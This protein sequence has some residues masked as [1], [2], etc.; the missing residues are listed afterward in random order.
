M[1]ISAKDVM[2]LRNKTGL[3]MMECKKAL[4][5][6]NGNVDEAETL[7][8][9]KLKGL[10]IENALIISGASVDE[11]FALAARNIPNIDVLPTQG[12]NVYDILRRHTLVLSKDALEAL[13]ERLK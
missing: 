4:Q 3:A 9:K 13:E 10:G 5:E 7:L 6:A 11:N 8:R 2:N 1:S 12:A